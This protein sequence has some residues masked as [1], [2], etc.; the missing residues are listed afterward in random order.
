MLL[1]KTVCK[2]ARVHLSQSLFHAHVCVYCACVAVKTLQSCPNLC[3]SVTV[4]HQAPLSMGFS[5][6]KYCSGWSCPP[7]GDLPDTGVKPWVGHLI[8]WQTG[9]FPLAPPGKPVC[10]WRN[11]LNII[12]TFILFWKYSSKV[13]LETS[14]T[15]T[16][17]AT[18]MPNVFLSLLRG[19][20]FHQKD[21][22]ESKKRPLF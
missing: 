11:E 18:K 12:N 19:N 22:L 13:L 1:L 8:Y 16:K 20:V 4:V 9:S 10:L 21:Y 14:K 6:Q 7:P 2:L 15:R 3:D 5:R 17:H